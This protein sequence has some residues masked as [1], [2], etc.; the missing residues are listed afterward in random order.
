[1]GI[2]H[3]FEADGCPLYSSQTPLLKSPNLKFFSINFDLPSPSH[4][5]PRGI[6][7]ISS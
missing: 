7:P 3:K 2:D 1:M 4:P 6:L 5:V